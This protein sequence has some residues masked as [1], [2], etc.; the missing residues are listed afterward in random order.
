MNGLDHGPSTGA[1]RGKNLEAVAG[2]STPREDHGGGRI[3]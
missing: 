3:L 2:F 1:L